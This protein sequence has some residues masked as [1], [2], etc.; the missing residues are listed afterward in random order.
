MS[1][2]RRSARLANKAY[3][4]SEAKKTVAVPTVVPRRSARIAH[5]TRASE[6]RQATAPV[7][8]AEPAPAAAPVAEPAPAPAHIKHIKITSYWRDKLYDDVA[9]E[10]WYF[11][12]N[13]TM[14]D[15]TKRT[16]TFWYNQV[17]MMDTYIRFGIG[18]HIA[19]HDGVVSL[20]KNGFSDTIY[21]P[22]APHITL[23]QVKGAF[24]PLLKGDKGAYQFDFACPADKYPYEFQTPVYTLSF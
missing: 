22:F 24:L 6:V 15:D 1:V 23:E 2:P 12:M 8:S 18:D 19:V 9:V 3:Y 21:I 16:S 7:V 5:L 14:S 10:D 20:V 13:I 17:G 11:T 4:A